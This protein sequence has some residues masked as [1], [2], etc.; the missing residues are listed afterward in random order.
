MDTA[1]FRPPFVGSSIYWYGIFSVTT[2][3][4]WRVVA[5]F[6]VDGVTDSLPQ[7]FGTSPLGCPSFDKEAVALFGTSCGGGGV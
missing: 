2:V 3:L 4:I 5:T 7:F 1:P 6:E